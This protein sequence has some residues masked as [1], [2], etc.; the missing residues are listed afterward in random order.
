[1]QNEAIPIL[2][3]LGMKLYTFPEYVELL[4]DLHCVYFW[5]MQDEIYGTIF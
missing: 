4:S 1:M 2:R 5:K 3:K